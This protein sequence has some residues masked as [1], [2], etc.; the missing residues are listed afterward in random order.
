MFLLG[1]NLH[2]LQVVGPFKLGHLHKVFRL[3]TKDN[4]SRWIKQWQKMVQA[5]YTAVA[6]IISVL[7]W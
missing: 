6:I 4:L 1:Y 5:D 3:A 7:M 2:V